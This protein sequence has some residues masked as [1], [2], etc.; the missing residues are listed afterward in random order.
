MGD[1]HTGRFEVQVEEGPPR[2]GLHELE[3]TTYY[4]VVERESGDVVM[5]LRG[6][7]EASLSTT[8]GMWDDYRVSGVC[9]VTITDDGRS[10][11]VRYHDGHEETRTIPR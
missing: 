9:G 3:Q 8:T 1:Q 4:R 5:T 10:V 2:G 6:E 7:L 11:H